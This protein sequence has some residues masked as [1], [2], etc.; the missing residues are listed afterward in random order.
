MMCSVEPHSKHDPRFQSG[1]RIGRRQRPGEDDPPGDESRERVGR[2]PAAAVKAATWF[3][4]LLISSSKGDE[5][6]GGVR[7]ATE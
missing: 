4:K 2:G 1:S 5:A 3:F 7:E 6:I